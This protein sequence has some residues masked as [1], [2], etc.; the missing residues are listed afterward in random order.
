MRIHKKKFQISQLNPKSTFAELNFPAREQIFVEETWGDGT[1]QRS[2]IRIELSAHET[3]E[4]LSFSPSTRQ[5]NWTSFYCVYVVAQKCSCATTVPLSHRFVFFP[6]L[7][8][9]FSTKCEFRQ[10]M[11]LSMGTTWISI[12]FPTLKWN[13]E[14]KNWE[15]LMFL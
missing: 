7:A 1:E 6:I 8:H 13:P 9:I 4:F 12:Y 14:P 15:S 3:Y 10:H 11:K 2:S 5:C